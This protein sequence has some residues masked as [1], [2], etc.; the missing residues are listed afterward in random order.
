MHIVVRTWPDTAVADVLT[1][2]KDEVEK[3]LREIPSFVSWHLVKFS[4]GT[5]STATTCNHKAGCDE[6]MKIS[7]EWLTK[8][9]PNV[10]LSKMHHKD[11][12]I[13]LSIG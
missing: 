6:S 5:C 1:Q 10:D 2:H 7:R 8:N 13:V 4:D 11:G 9:A 3:L 12:E